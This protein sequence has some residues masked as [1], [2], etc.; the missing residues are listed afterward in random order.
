MVTGGFKVDPIELGLLLVWKFEVDLVELA[1]GLD[2]VV[3]E[4]VIK[5][6]AKIKILFKLRRV[7]DV[8]QQYSN[9]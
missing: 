1:I 4:V 5:H 8:I 9:V 2:E 6:V 7:Y 3:I